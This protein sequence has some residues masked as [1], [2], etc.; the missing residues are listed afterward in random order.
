MHACRD[1]GNVKA[2]AGPGTWQRTELRLETWTFS[3]MGVLEEGSLL[4]RELQP[5]RRPPG[6][7]VRPRWE[8]KQWWPCWS[9]CDG[10]CV[11]SSVPIAQ[12][13]GRK[14]SACTKLHFLL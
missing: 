14:G 12:E 10:L 3:G 11:W 5:R 2:A 4:C 7:G 13:A 8:E 1:L 6:A 9:V